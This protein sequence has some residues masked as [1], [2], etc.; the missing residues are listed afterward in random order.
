ME[1]TKNSEPYFSHAFSDMATFI[2]EMKRSMTAREKTSGGISARSSW[3]GTNLNT[4]N[5]LSNYS[6]IAGAFGFGRSP[7][8]SLGVRSGSDHRNKSP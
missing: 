7:T 1:R 6:A 8:N 5:S 2:K 3:F 4:I